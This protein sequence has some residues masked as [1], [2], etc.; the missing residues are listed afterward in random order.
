M[1]FSK[2]HPNKS[3]VQNV[4]ISDLLKWTPGCG[5]KPTLTDLVSRI[6]SREPEA[7]KKGS[8]WKD[9]PPGAKV[10]FLPDGGEDYFSGFYEVPAKKKLTLDDAIDR[11]HERLKAPTYPGEVE[12]AEGLLYQVHTGKYNACCRSCDETY[13]VDI[14]PEDISTWDQ[15]VSYCGKSQWCLP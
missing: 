15:D 1:I 3:I 6:K 2:R 7:E 12:V 5:R 8:F 10:R 4:K 13:E 11:L 9:I 14:S